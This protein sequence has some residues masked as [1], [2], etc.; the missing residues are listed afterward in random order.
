MCVTMRAVSAKNGRWWK[1]SEL[2]ELELPLQPRTTWLWAASVKKVAYYFNTVTPGKYFLKVIW[3]KR[4][5]LTDRRGAGPGDYESNWLGPIQLAAGSS[6]TNP[7]VQCAQRAK[8]G[9]EYYAADEQALR[10][11]NEAESLQTTELPKAK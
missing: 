6:V 9:D 5:P 2:E 4:P 10:K 11:W 1:S 8:G 7:I 3:D